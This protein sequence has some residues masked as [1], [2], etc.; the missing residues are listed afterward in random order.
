MTTSAFGDGA[1][2]HHLGQGGHP[3]QLY[4]LI[5]EVPALLDRIARLAV[6]SLVRLVGRAQEVFDEQDHRKRAARAPERR[7]EEPR[8]EAPLATEEW[9]QVLAGN[10][11]GGYAVGAWPHY[12]HTGA[13]EWF[14]E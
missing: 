5:E 11:H 9:G 13:Q 10:S 8:H 1:L 6:S 12:R 14:T 3:G 2:A 4:L 7:D